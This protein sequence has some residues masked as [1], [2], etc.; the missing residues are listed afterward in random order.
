MKLHIYEH[1][2]YCT[3]AR[4]IFGMKNIPVSLSVVMEGDAETP[5]R[6]VGKK[7][8]P[9]LIRED[10][11][12]M[13]ESMDIVRY[14]DAQFGSR[15][16]TRAPRPEIDAWCGDG[17]GFIFKLA[18]P[19]MT[20]GQ[21]AEIGTPESGEAFRLREMKA[22]GDLDALIADT[23]TLLG[24]ANEHLL[25]LE[26]LLEQWKGYSESDLVLFSILRMLS[27]ARG[28]VFGPNARAFADEMARIGGVALLNDQAV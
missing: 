25:L 11:T 7:V 13:P 19:R 26:P 23:P 21:F 15:I 2:P 6:L 12:A 27:I 9:I 28:V 16:L 1:C 5:T 8:V 20:K 18:V 10:G 4:M 3:R 22:F 24:H 14:I 17:R